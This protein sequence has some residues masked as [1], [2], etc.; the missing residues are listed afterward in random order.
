MEKKTIKNNIQT[1]SEIQKKKNCVQ[2]R[3]EYYLSLN[4][5]Y[6]FIQNKKFN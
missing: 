5:I 2:R 6:H 1:K 3:R 4:L